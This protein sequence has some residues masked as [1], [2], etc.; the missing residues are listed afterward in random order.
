MASINWTRQ[1]ALAVI[2]VALGSGAIYL[3]YRYTPEKE[4]AAEREKKIFLIEGQTI[5]SIVIRQ[6]KATVELR[7][8]QPEAGHCKV[9]DIGSWEMIRPLKTS[10]DSATMHSLLTSLGALETSQ[11]IDLS[12]DEATAK[13]SLLKDYGLDSGSRGSGAMIEVKSASGTITTLHV[14]QTHPLGDT[15]FTLLGDQENEVKLVPVAFKVNLEREVNHWRNKQLFPQSYTPFTSIRLQQ[16][17]SSEALVAKKFDHE[18][19]I[20]LERPS[21]AKPL[22]TIRADEGKIMGYITTAKS[23]TAE[24]FVAE[25]KNGPEGQAALAPYRPVLTLNLDNDSAQSPEPT[26]TAG[27][28]P[29]PKAYEL[30]LYESKNRVSGKE[31]S[32]ILATMSTQPMIYRL[33]SSMLARMQKSLKDFRTL[34]ILSRAQKSKLKQIQFSGEMLTEAVTM[35]QSGDVW[36]KGEAPQSGQAPAGE[37]STKIIHLLEGLTQASVQEYLGGPYGKKLASEV[38]QGRKKG[39]TVVLRFPSTSPTPSPTTTPEPLKTGAPVTD[40]KNWIFWRRNG[41][42]YAHCAAL[43]PEEVYLLDG[44]LLQYLPWNDDYFKASSGDQPPNKNSKEPSSMLHAP[45]D[46]S[47]GS[48]SKTSDDLDLEDE[49][50]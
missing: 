19:N 8:V 35:S 7:C 48:S 6:P 49:D 11:T 2:L 16:N 34:E 36:V 42:L 14:G 20:T 10:A 4:K 30:V 33:D 32:G 38:L 46:L 13:A 24:A 43:N 25:D 41:L 40:E 45:N 15:L 27:I 28:P 39:L 12:K 22:Q 47:N 18:W 3:E 44:S 1:F 17:G 31:P 50:S 21:A 5:E 29:L 37:L 26:P 9:N 23:L